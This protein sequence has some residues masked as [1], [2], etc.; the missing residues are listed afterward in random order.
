MKK[1]YLKI[2][3]FALII[4]VIGIFAIIS[5]SKD[6]L[7][8]QIPNKQKTTKVNEPAGY[9]VYNSLPRTTTCVIPTVATL[10]AAETINIGTVTVTNTMDSVYITYATTG[11]WEMELLH[12][13]V[14]NISVVSTDPAGNPDVENLPYR[15]T[16]DPRSTVVTFVFPG[17]TFSD[18][19]N[20]AAYA[21]V[22]KVESGTVIQNEIAWAG[23]TKFT[24]SGWASY[25]NAH[26]KTCCTFDTIEYNI[27]ADETNKIGVL[28]V[29]NDQQNL[30]ITFTTIGN[31]FYGK[32]FL[33]VGTLDKMPIK[34]SKEPETDKFTC[35]KSH[36]PKVHS[37]TYT[38]SLS[39]LPSTF[40][41]AAYSEAHR[42]VNGYVVQ[43]EETWS[44]GK[45]YNKFPHCS[46]WGWYTTYTVQECE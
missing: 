40:I 32:T 29:T 6:E 7:G 27:Y 2:K 20:V 8:K 19:F 38:I 44:K 15:A 9:T 39:S 43:T 14:G 5:C 4:P 34:K 42:M 30:N 3:L 35:K 13:F 37:Y 1:F 22:Y 46:H 25:F 11:G 45:K 31:W 41:I 21:D 16:L 26:K 28:K 36:S 24:E 33:Y 23:G 10:Y 17:S 12:L 18:T